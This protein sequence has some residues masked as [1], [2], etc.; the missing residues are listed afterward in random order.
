MLPESA[1]EKSGE[2][3]NI[4]AVAAVVNHERLRG[5]GD[6]LPGSVAPDSFHLI[7]TSRAYPLFQ[8][9]ENGAEVAGSEP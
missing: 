8:L 5:G 3:G 7:L 1:D 9:T 2:F 4:E 6:L